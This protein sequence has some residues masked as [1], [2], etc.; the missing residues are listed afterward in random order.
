M[1]GEERVKFWVD[2]KGRDDRISWSTECGCEEKRVVKDDLDAFEPRRKQKDAEESLGG[3]GL[4][5]RLGAQ[6]KTCGV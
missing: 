2:F 6:F 3:A 5:G 4:G 1:E